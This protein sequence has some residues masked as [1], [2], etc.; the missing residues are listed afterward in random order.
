MTNLLKQFENKQLKQDGIPEYHPGD[1]V[2]VKVQIEEGNRV[3]T[4]AFEGVV[5]KKRDRS[6]STSIT[7][8]KISN[9]EGVERTFKIHSPLVKSIVVKRHGKVRQAK[10]YYI[11]DLT[12]KKARIAEKRRVKPAESK[13]S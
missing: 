9:G 11:R 2:V 7:V 3:R 12:A 8:R 6:I 4:Q 1:T 5:I 10:L 13:K